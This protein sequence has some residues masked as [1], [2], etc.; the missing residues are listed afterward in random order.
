MRV[1]WPLRLIGVF[2]LLAQLAFS[3]GGNG[4][5]TGTI[6]DPSGSV[7]AGATVEAKNTETG[8]SYTG[9]STAAGNYAIPNLPVGTYTLS[10]TVP[11][12]KTYTHSNLALAATQV[13]REDIRMEVGTAA[14]SVTVEAEATLLKT[15]TGD[16]SHNVTLEQMQ[17]L[18]MLGIGTVNAGTSGVRNPYNVLQ[19]LPGVSSY[20]TSGV[21][22]INGLGGQ[23]GFSVA[24]SETMRI[25]GQDATSRIFGNYD[26]TQMAQ[27][28][29]DAI[30]EV[31]YQTS[32]YA[33][34]YG[35]AGNVVINMTMKSG[36]NQY[37]GTGFDYFVNEDLNAGNP[38][39][40]SSGNG[41]KFRPRNRRNDFG[42]TLGG[43]ISIPKIYNGKDKTFFFFAY[44]QYLEN[45]TY[46]FNDTVPTADY[47]NGNFSHI[48]PNG[49]CALCAA[50]GIP[51]GP[52]GGPTYTDAK[53]RPMYANEIYDPT[54]RGVTAGNL[55]FADP[56]TNNVIPPS[57]FN[58]TAKAMQKLF[59]AAQNSNVINNYAGTVGGN[60]YTAIPSI[61][62]DHI[63]TSRD[64]L[65]FY[66]SRINTESQISSPLGNAD[67][68]P[69]EIGAYRGTFIPTWTTR[70]NYDRT[71]TPTLLLHLGGG[72]YHTSFSDRA[73]FLNFD[74]TQFGLNGFI[75][76]RQFPSVTGMCGQLSGPPGTP[77]SCI[78]GT[79]TNAVGQ[80]F[81]GFGG[82]QN[83][84]TSGQIQSQ[85][86]EEKPS[87]NANATWVKGNHTFKTG[88]ELYL[89]Q[90]YTGSFS[91]VTLAL[92]SSLGVPV[93]TAQ[94]FTPTVSFGG[95]TQGF[96]YASFLLGD[97]AST[98]Q[99]PGEF[100]REGSQAWGLFLQDSWKVTRKLTVD[101]GLRWD[102]A[103][104]EHEQ[105]GRLAQLDPTAPN[106]N[107]GGHPGA[108]RYANTCNCPFYMPAYPYGIGPRLGVAYQ[109]TPKTV[110]RG[111]WGINYQFIAN[112][113]GT[114]IGT[115]AVVLPAGV[116]PYVDITAPGSILQPTWP[117]TDPNIYP[118]K[119]SVGNPLVPNT[120]PNVPDR[121]ENRPPRINQF[122]IGFQREITRNLVIEAS[123]VGNRA[124][125]LSA[126]VFGPLGYLSQIS[127]QR[128]ASFGLYPYPGTGPC[129]SGGSVCASTTYN[130]YADYLLM[131]QP[132]NSAPVVSAMAARGITNLSPYPGFPA[133][134]SLQSTLYPFP[135]YGNLAVSNSA[136]GNSK[137]DSLQAKLTK[138]LSH[139]IQAGGSFTWGQ[140][141]V[142]PTRQDFFNPNSN[143]W[144]LQQIPPFDLNFNIVYTVPKLAIL[145]KYANAI[146]K[147]WQIGW[148]ANY[149]SGQFLT[150]P[151]SPNNIVNLLPS[152]D[153][154]VPNQPLYTPGV[155]IN[156]HS[157]YN[158]YYTQV[159]NPKAW[160]PCPTNAV[161]AATSTFYKDFRG[162]RTPIENANIGRHF[163]FGKEGKYDFYLRGEF[164]N[165]F[166]RTLMPNPITTGNPANPPIRGAGGGTIFN[167]GFGV[168]NAYLPANTVFQPPTGGSQLLGRTGTL[169]ARFSF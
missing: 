120:T 100:T 103:T 76:H 62:A 89:E 36:T 90:T 49:D 26:Y 28:N 102:Y 169:I 138:R 125:W 155:N 108:V 75:Q 32:N 163:R 94:P 21:F 164:V 14:E 48:S 30:Q 5:L 57:M 64:K 58:A 93:G 133:N 99:T 18:P 152:E 156:D 80:V 84:G 24:L 124:V 122:S 162:P 159:L 71:M 97:Y 74:P 10:A 77:T 31:A 111:G 132:I 67:G 16:L 88:A 112:A 11:G 46:N 168:I 6:T 72:Y 41:G 119:G 137:Y 60:R 17:D 154:R 106:A 45:N 150:P 118:T 81:S 151:T 25:E 22:A 86:Y 123:Y 143:P 107:A 43:P 131:L 98:T 27:P 34:E 148:F 127:P 153:I 51:T 128:Y 146:V 42:G 13:L 40:F 142:R 9:A 116:N 38:F 65:S 141:F 55:G 8:V 15:E 139:G 66:W 95:F 92:Q 52:L 79:Q 161:C 114:T 96:S 59:P 165:I 83:I 87:F 115:N 101:Y 47:L 7:I 105:H 69:L 160:A 3:Q 1:S 20:A 129:A 91:G 33:P 85:N 12:F 147:D 19:T 44:E 53:G 70:L 145:P 4:T 130:N 110:F 109:I 54:T 73:P 113:A 35:Q 39:S 78:Q 144:Q 167:G 166:N 135:Q 29:A 50:L 157:T 37:H 117:V 68:L 104:P 126:G 2:G 82:M 23:N 63:I 136:T 158:P 61:K 56:F 140:G 121:N 149:Q 134:N